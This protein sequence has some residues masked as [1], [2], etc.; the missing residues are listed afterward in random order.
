MAVQL[1]KWRVPPYR[2]EA[3]PNM[4]GEMPWQLQYTLMCF[5]V[6]LLA[7]IACT[8]LIEKPGA[9]LGRRAFDRIARERKDS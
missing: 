7:A 8:Y 2:A 3:D 1:K 5:A 4:A 9:R 6:A